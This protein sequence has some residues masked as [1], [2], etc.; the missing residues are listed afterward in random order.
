MIPK[1][2][3]EAN[4]IEQILNPYADLVFQI[5]S[6]LLWGNPLGLA[7]ALTILNSVLSIVL[8]L[9]LSF[10]PTFFFILMIK[11]VLTGPLRPYIRVL[12]SQK[13]G[14]RYSISEIAAS[15]AKC[16]H[17]LRWIEERLFPRGRGAVVKIVIV[18]GVLAPLIWFFVWV[19]TFWVAFGFTN[20]AVLLPG[21]VFHPEVV[22]L[23]RRRRS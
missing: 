2:I 17:F 22:K 18:L 11:A 13:S 9:G 7:V 20:L 23:V 10:V 6:I 19:E 3:S 15:L 16:G 5:E 21:V 14:G 8:F 1:W 4:A 12:L